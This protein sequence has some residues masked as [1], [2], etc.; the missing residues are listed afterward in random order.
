[1]AG[2]SENTYTIPAQTPEDPALDYQTLRSIGFNQIATLSTNFWTDFN[3]HDPGITILE[4][5]SYAITD[6]GYRANFPIEDIIAQSRKTQAELQQS[7]FQTAREVLTNEPVTYEDFRKVLLDIQGVTNAWVLTF[8]GFN[9]INGLRKVVIEADERIVSPA[10]LKLL[11]DQVSEVFRCHRNLCEDLHQIE[12]LTPRIFNLDFE[13]SLEDGVDPEKIVATAIFEM[14]QYLQGWVSFLTLDGMMAA[15]NNQTD[16]VFEGPALTH[17]FIPDAV[18]KPK[19]EKVTQSDLIGIVEQVE[20]VKNILKL[21]ILDPKLQYYPPV[22][23]PPYGAT[24]Y[25]IPLPKTGVLYLTESQIPRFGDLSN[26]VLKVNIGRTPY[27]LNLNKVQKYLDLFDNTLEVSKRAPNPAAFDLPIPMGRYR[28]IQYYYSVQYDFPVIYNLRPNALP[29]NAPDQLRGE[30]KQLQAYLLI[31]DQIMA[32]FLAQLAH[33]SDLYSWT[34]DES[35]TYFFSGLETAVANLTDLINTFPLEPPKLAGETKNEEWK[36]KLPDALEEYK[37]KLGKMRETPNEFRDRRNL[38]LSH[39]LARVGRDLTKYTTRLKFKSEKEKEVY[40]I[41]RSEEILQDYPNF[42][43]KRGVGG[44]P[45]L[46]TMK[47]DGRPGLKRVVSEIFGLPAITPETE[48]MNDRFTMV[49][50]DPLEYRELS[51]FQFIRTKDGSK[52]DMAYL[53]KIGANEDNYKVFGIVDEFHPPYTFW[54]FETGNEKKDHHVFSTP[55]QYSSV[56]EAFANIKMLTEMFAEYDYTSEKIYILDHLLFRPYSSQP[57]FGANILDAD[58]NVIMT[59]AFWYSEDDLNLLLGINS[60]N[61]TILLG[62]SLVPEY[63]TQ[64]FVFRITATADGTPYPVYPP[65]G[66]AIPGDFSHFSFVFEEPETG[67]LV[68]K[69]IE[70]NYSSIISQPEAL[71]K[72]LIDDFVDVELP[73]DWKSGGKNQMMAAWGQFALYEILKHKYPSLLNSPEALGNKLLADLPILSETGY[74]PGHND[75]HLFLEFVNNQYLP[76]YPKAA[77]LANNLLNDLSD[78]PT[79]SKAWTWYTQEYAAIIGRKL[80]IGYFK[81]LFPELLDDP[82]KLG[83]DIATDFLFHS[84]YQLE[85]KLNDVCAEEIK[86]IAFIAVPFLDG[87][88]LLDLLLDSTGANKLLNEPQVRK[89]LAFTGWRLIQQ[90]LNSTWIVSIDDPSQLGNDLYVHYS[91]IGFPTGN[92]I[93]IFDLLSESTEYALGAF[94]EQF[95]PHRWTDRL[96]LGTAV[97]EDFLGKTP[98]SNLSKSAQELQLAQTGLAAL[99]VFIRNQLS[100]AGMTENSPYEDILDVLE[101]WVTP[102][103]QSLSPIGEKALEFYIG[104]VYYPLPKT[105]KELGQNLINDFGKKHPLPTLQLAKD[106]L[107]AAG[108]YFL[109]SYLK[110]ELLP[111]L[112]TGTTMACA[113]I[114][115][116]CPPPIDTGDETGATGAGHEVG[117]GAPEGISQ[118]DAEVLISQILNTDTDQA[119]RNEMMA[120]GIRVKVEEPAGNVIDLNTGAEEDKTGTNSA[121]GAENAT[122]S[123]DTTGSKEETGTSREDTGHSTPETGLP[124]NDTGGSDPLNPTGEDSPT[125]GDGGE[126]GGKILSPLTREVLL[127]I[128]HYVKEAEKQIDDILNGI[129]LTTGLESGNIIDDDEYTGHIPDLYE[130]VSKV[131]LFKFIVASVPWQLDNPAAID[132]AITNYIL[133]PWKVEFLKTYE[134]RIL[135]H[136]GHNLIYYYLQTRFPWQ[137]QDPIS[138]GKSVATLYS[139]SIEEGTNTATIPDLTFLPIEPEVE[140]FVSL[141]YEGANSLE[142]IYSP[143]QSYESQADAVE[144]VKWMVDCIPEIENGAVKFSAIFEALL[145][146]ALVPGYDI[147]EYPFMKNPYSNIITIVAPNWPTRFQ[148]ESFQAVFEKALQEEAPAQIYY[149]VLWLDKLE[150]QYFEENYL[151]W[152]EEPWGDIAKAYTST[153][154]LTFIIEKL[155]GT[156]NPWIIYTG[157]NGNPKT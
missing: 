120:E 139:L 61:Y 34:S 73:A 78:Q 13:I 124:H 102:A 65:T 45:A 82:L 52:V 35:R 51:P 81:R 85:S 31:F 94:I 4:A 37:M 59:T 116:L 8:D 10:D 63:P 80:G 14:S 144:I 18:L 137:I 101:I 109:D 58:Q 84:S 155:Y 121:T 146:P 3:E 50:N 93:P 11:K 114:P 15:S 86:A 125:G 105:Y 12:F 152:L 143:V 110:D 92:E 97:T 128:L 72:A 148:E 47:P 24:A 60:R 62:Q 96:A 100:L 49:W 129:T 70:E 48:A 22:T 136:P 131:G 122:G 130:L 75:W 98:S 5:L 134:A 141:E 156:K 150:Y 46:T 16:I 106:A 99:D 108:G 53:M 67:V 123:D 104:N 140:Y 27:T 64:P 28:N 107:S 79:K 20:G 154:I 38:F 135:A 43:S 127:W 157:D 133:T 145:L 103:E 126:T 1:M 151:G 95:I 71:G 83:E 115:L 33:I 68:M 91:T 142:V 54:L 88:N 19:I 21:K 89:W 66:L 57:N 132:A 153:R 41:N 74:T 9:P 119:I 6:L 44:D 111:T 56:E 30:V 25:N 112:E 149:N 2:N 138:L 40:L 69:Y 76:L 77:D 87:A 23:P 29:P 7:Q 32:D 42:S 17:G 39:L 36:A 26:W 113:L 55:N 117:T 118:T 90:Y 147:G